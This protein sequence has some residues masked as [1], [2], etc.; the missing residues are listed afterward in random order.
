M[1]VLTHVLQRAFRCESQV[2]KEGHVQVHVPFAPG[3]RVSVFVIEES[4]ETM[5]ELMEASQSS[6]DFW[7]NPFDD[8]DWNDV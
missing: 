6:L 5:H 8:E 3:A 2:E 1:S 7:D 4:P